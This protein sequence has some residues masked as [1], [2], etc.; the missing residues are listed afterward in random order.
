LDATFENIFTKLGVQKSRLRQCGDCTF[1][2]Q[3]NIFLLQCSF[4]S[5]F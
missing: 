3:F 5:L 4:S 1:V 2:M